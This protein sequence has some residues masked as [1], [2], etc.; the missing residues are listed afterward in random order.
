MKKLVLSTLV[1]A[2]FFS[3]ASVAKPLK[4]GVSFQEMNNEY[5]VVMKEALAEA[6]DSVGGQ[7]F[8]TD[9]AHDIVKQNNDVEDLVSKDIDI[10]ILNPTDSEGV[11][12]A[13][14][15]AKAKNVTV[16]S[17][18]AQAAGPI[19]SFVGSKNYDAGVLACEALSKEIKGKGEVA[20]LDGIPVV[21]ILERVRGCKDALAKY[22]AIKLVDI[23]NG[24]QDRTVAMGVTEN[25]I[26]AHP[27]LAGIFSVN[28][29][30][31]MGSLAAIE[32]SG[33]N[34]VLTSVDGASEAIS[35]ILEGSPFK[36]TAAQYPRDQLRI[37]FAMALA[38]H[39]GA[40]VPKAI[41]VDVKLIDKTN[42]KGF[43]W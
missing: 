41:P 3:V 14:E 42:A 19:D 24:K 31:A 9:A 23:Q 39:W 35:A 17:V 26:Q 43:S 18:D 29:G 6:V 36:A 25:M 5:F 37:G 12:N 1:A 27:N 32:G 34:I 7:L 10:L 38:K 20:I 16:V 40:N 22:P 15:F 21:P 8:I 4:V 11:K 30:G 33:K 2:S 28:D 13:V